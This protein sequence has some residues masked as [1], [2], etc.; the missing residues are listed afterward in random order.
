MTV[1]LSVAMS[2]SCINIKQEICADQ[3]QPITISYAVSLYLYFTRMNKSGSKRNK[4]I[5][6]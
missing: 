2:Q 3:Y 5:I 6:N 1:L 4:K